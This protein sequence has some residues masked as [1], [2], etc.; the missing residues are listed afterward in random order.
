MLSRLE[1]LE[2]PIGLIGI[3]YLRRQPTNQ[4]ECASKEISSDESYTNQSSM[5]RLPSWG[6]L[7]K[8]TI[9]LLAEELLSIETQWTSRVEHIPRQV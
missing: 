7:S 6:A 5:S 2:G 9:I 8:S 3:F 1:S 4:V